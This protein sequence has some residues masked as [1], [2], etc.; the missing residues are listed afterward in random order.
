[1]RAF[2][3]ARGM[4]PAVIILDG[5]CYRTY[6]SVWC[7]INLYGIRPFVVIS[8]KFHNERA[9]FLTSH[10]DADIDDVVGYNASDVKTDVAL[11]T[12]LGSADLPGWSGLS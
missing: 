6:D 9:V 8:Q 4:S 3:I 7:T 11:L 2:L 5:K 12:Y 1:M 10:L